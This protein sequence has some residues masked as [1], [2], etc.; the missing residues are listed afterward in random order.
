[1]KTRLAVGIGALALMIPP[2]P[3]RDLAT[4]IDNYLRP[5]VET[6]NFSGVIYIERGEQVLFQRGYGLASPTFAIP[7]TPATRFH[8]ASISKAFTA[9][10]Y[11]LDMI[12]L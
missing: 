2:V 10:T 7:N 6:N 1:M 3:Q 12:P 8:I 4:R 11:F 9:K 5:F